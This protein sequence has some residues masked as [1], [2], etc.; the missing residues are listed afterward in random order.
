M[1][2]RKVTHHSAASASANGAVMNTTGLV[3]TLVQITGTYVGTVTFQ[4]TI[5]GST[6]VAIQGQN[7]NTGATASTA[8]TPGLYFVSFAGVRLFR[9]PLIW[10]S[11]TS[12]TAMSIGVGN[13]VESLAGSRDTGAWPTIGAIELRANNSGWA[14]WE[15]VARQAKYWMGTD[16]NRQFRHGPWAIHMNGGAQ[17][18]GEDWAS[19]QI[20]INE[21][22]LIDLDEIQFNYYKFLAG[23]AA[24]GATG[25]NIVLSAHD[26]ADHDETVDINTTASQ[27]R[28]VTAGWH[29]ITMNAATDAMF[30]Y[31]TATDAALSSGTTTSHTWAD[32]QADVAF[33]TW[34]VYR[35]QID[36]GF[37][38]DTRSTGDAWIGSIQINNIAVKMEPADLNDLG[39]RKNFSEPTFGEPTLMSAQNGDAVWSRANATE[40]IA[41]LQKGSTG[42]T[43]NLYGGLQKLGA[44]GGRSWA[45]VYIPVNELPVPM[46]NTARWTYWFTEAEEHG[47]SM[48]VWVHDPYDFDK[49]AE[50]SQRAS[51]ADL[52]RAQYWNAHE[53]NQTTDQFFYMGENEANSDLDEGTGYSYGWDDFQG[54]EMF[55]TWTIYRISFCIGWYDAV[56]EFKDAWLADISLNNEQI[57][58]KPDS[59]GTG[60][61]GHRHFTTSSGDLTGALAPKTPFRLLA[62][63]FHTSAVLAAGDLLTI[64]KDAWQGVF[65]D[66][67]IFSSD[68]GALALTSLYQTFEG[69]QMFCADDILNVLQNN[70][71]DGDLGCTLWY[72]TVFGG[73]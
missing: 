67:L 48:T 41:S 64:T 36:Y 16:L 7:T 29:E 65:Y 66:T 37:W 8:T 34:T 62:F 27:S 52:E 39:T 4:G 50:I 59:S 43:A 1:I 54:D 63:D 72:Q 18:S 15:R 12:I 55:N 46:F 68:V 53:L 2:E 11:G 23:T 40:T 71:S 73:M 38:G 14:L 33:K 56:T 6:W 35:I 60:R 3:G 5:D 31:G 61:I 22:P 58:L 49:R 51:H 69:V 47:I 9:A 25:P 70:A 42:W 32:F 44:S 30:Y 19:V 21:M 13:A 10:T 28:P 24:V 26:P 57:P 20:P 17:A 45:A